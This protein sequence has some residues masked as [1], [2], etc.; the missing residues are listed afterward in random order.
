VPDCLCAV[1]GLVLLVALRFVMLTGDCPKDA[2]G[3]SCPMGAVGRR[4]A[5]R[6][7]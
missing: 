7:V 3:R 4:R 1:S 2:V 6:A 5:L